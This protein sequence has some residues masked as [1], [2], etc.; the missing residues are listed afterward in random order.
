MGKDLIEET[1]VLIRLFLFL[2]QEVG[3]KGELTAKELRELIKII[4]EG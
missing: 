4:K 3:L 2:R 1:K